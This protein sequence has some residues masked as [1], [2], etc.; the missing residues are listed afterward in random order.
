MTDP[1]LKVIHDVGEVIGREAIVLED[2]LIVHLF[3]VEGDR[4]DFATSKN[5]DGAFYHNGAIK[6][7]NPSHPKKKYDILTLRLH[8]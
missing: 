6:N 4:T 5:P 2:Y 7:M 3:V 1:H 8:R